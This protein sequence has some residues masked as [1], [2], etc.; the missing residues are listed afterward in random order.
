MDGWHVENVEAHL[1]D[2]R[3][4]LLDVL[5]SSSFARLA[6]RARKELVPGREARFDRVDYDLE[7]FGICRGKAFV[8]VAGHQLSD[9][10]PER[11]RRGSATLAHRVGIGLQPVR[12]RAVRP[13]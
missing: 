1:G 8:G 2:S 10:V 12:V 9:L 7:V 5:E 11:G 6:G 4:T 13:A 3:Q